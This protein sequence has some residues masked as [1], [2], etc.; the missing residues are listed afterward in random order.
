[1]INTFRLFY[2]FVSFSLGIILHQW[3]HVSFGLICFLC[4]LTWILLII[5]SRK[6]FVFILMVILFLNLGYLYVHSR[7]ILFKDHISYVSKY[8]RNNPIEIKGQIVSDV[9]TRR[10][11]KTKKTSFFLKVTKIKAPWGWENRQ[12]KILVN[13]FRD[14][15]LFYGDV[16]SLKGKLHKPFNFKTKGSFSYQKYLSNRDVHFILSVKNSSE[17]KKES[18]S[19]GIY[20]LK[21]VYRLRNYFKKINNQYLS[22][23]EA[24]IMNALL[25]GDRSYIPKNVRQLFVMTG[26]AHILAI[27]GLHMGI[28]AL[29]LMM[30]FRL[31]PVHRI[32]QFLCVIVFLL[33]YMMLAG[34]RVS[35]LRA[36]IMI[37]IFLGS[38]I[39]ERQASNLNTLFLA[40]FIIALINPLYLFDV[41]FQLSFT[42]VLSIFLFVPMFKK[43][44]PK[45][46]PYLFAHILD[47]LCVSFAV[48]IG[49]G[50]LIMYYFHVMTPI[51]IVANLIV[52]PLLM[53]LLILGF[54]LMF[55][56]GISA[57]LAGVFSICIKLTLNLMVGSVFLLSKI[58]FSNIV[59]NDVS[60][61]FTCIYY[62]IVMLLYCFAR[63]IDKR[64][65]IC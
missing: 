35:V 12:G 1:M 9:E 52:V 16:I 24:G 47:S 61:V 3:V 26:T 60:L 39:F 19:G 58:P 10:F 50:G 40:G 62:S 57:F 41:G 20:F 31:L 8:Y 37:V 55:L 59:I 65:R 27:S 36:T 44:I 48:W 7:T 22:P 63:M 21:S 45:K 46:L 15:D 54:G 38:H 64:L 51:S 28:I 14:R 6:M 4:I 49:V 5:V 11:L 18:K 30:F 29:I 56:G 34:F 23:K 25:L 13:T 43:V 2:I 17:I 32:F 42:C 53:A 33:G